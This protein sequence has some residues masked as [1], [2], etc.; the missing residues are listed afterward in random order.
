[1]KVDDLQ[2]FLPNPVPP[3]IPSL[4]SPTLP[5]QLFL[6]MLNPVLSKL[7]HVVF[8]TDFDS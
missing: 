4:D 2:S 3:I 1:V 7:C 6:I 5:F 8:S